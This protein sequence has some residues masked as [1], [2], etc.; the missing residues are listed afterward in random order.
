MTTEPVELGALIDT[1]ERMIGELQNGLDPE[2]RHF[3]VPKVDR[4]HDHDEI[5]S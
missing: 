2:E 5:T 4:Q 3:L 1:R